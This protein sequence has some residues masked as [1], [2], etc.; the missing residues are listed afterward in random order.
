MAQR[1]I[2]DCS[3]PTSTTTPLQGQLG[4]TMFFVRTGSLEVRVALDLQRYLAALATVQCVR[5]MRRADLTSSRADE[6]DPDSFVLWVT[7][8]MR[9]FRKAKVVRLPSRPPPHPPCMPLQRYLS[10]TCASTRPEKRG[11]QLAFVRWRR[12]GKASSDFVPC[13]GAG[14]VCH[15]NLK[16]Q[17]YT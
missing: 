7:N 13:R 6:D 10:Q 14:L 17:R 4:Y 8:A 11:Q 16:V 1:A 2:A 9:R 12:C 15:H 5:G 3:K